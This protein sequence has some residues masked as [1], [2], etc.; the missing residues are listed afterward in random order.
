MHFEHAGWRVALEGRADGVR[1]RGAARVIEELKSVAA[2]PAGPAPE[3]AAALQVRTYAWMWSRSHAEPCD[4]ELVWLP[5]D[6]PDAAVREPVAVD[7]DALEAELRLALDGCLTRLAV[8]AAEGLA[9]RRAAPSVR[10]PFPR[11]RP[12]QAEVAE[13]V[14]R[15]LAEREHLLVE[16][17]TGLGKTLAALVPALRFALAEGKRLAVLAPTGLAQRAAVAALESL[18]P[19]GIVAAVRLRAKARMC[20]GAELVC[21]EAVCDFARDYGAKLERGGLVARLFEAGPVVEPDRVFALG[22]AARACPFELSLDAARAAVVTVGDFNYAFDPGTA[23]FAAGDPATREL[24]IVADEVHRLAD[25]AREARSAVLEE[26]A[27]LHAAQACAFGGGTLHRAQSHALCRVAAWA[28]EQAAEALGADAGPDL[29]DVTGTLEPSLEGL[30]TL[31]DELD[32]LLAATLAYR[33]ATRAFDRNDPFLDACHAVHR[34][35][36]TTAP[37]AGVFVTL[38]SSAGG[39]ARLHRLCLDPGPS[40]ARLFAR[41]HAFVGLSATLGAAELCARTLGLDPARTAVLRVR[42]PFPRERRRLVI[43]AGVDTRARLRAVEIP[44]IARRL[45]AFATAVPGSC[46]ALLPSHATLAAV[47][48]ALPPVAHAL[49]WQQPDEGEAE[50]AAHLEALAGESPV[51]LLAVAGGVFAESIDVAG[52]RLRAVAVVGPCLPAPSPERELLR[53]HHDAGDG[54]GFERVYV[55]PG[56]ARVI[57]AAGRLIRSESDRGV[58]AL[59]GRRFLAEPFRS[60]IPEAWLAGRAPEAWVGEP[61]RVAAAFFAAP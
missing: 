14:G 22:C 54:Q 23:L 17:P 19:P 4:A 24:V 20:A 56:M 15:A 27:L 41:C 30:E 3:A 33:A 55:E 38:A 34:F 48:A 10:T 59:F 28:R 51:L 50:R 42:D 60:R 6:E 31:R 9:R 35:L 61:A 40:L 18:A 21:H 45:A 13:A 1:R 5:L 36:G 12:G 49:R 39:A 44:E 53:A 58:I 26:A 46:L 16:A 29:P 11:W 32:A 25:R 52:G 8:R 2:L 43:D 47:R 7:A 37:E 57:Q